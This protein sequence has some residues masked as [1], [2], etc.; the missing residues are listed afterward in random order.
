[1]AWMRWS[2]PLGSAILLVACGA[3][4]APRPTC[5]KTKAITDT[6]T[7]GQAA[8]EG[9]RYDPSAAILLFKASSSQMTIESRCN[10]RLVHKL[11]P[12]QRLASGS[13]APIAAPVV[14]TN[15]EF[16]L[17][18]NPDTMELQ[19]SAHCFFRV[20]DPRVPTQEESATRLDQNTKKA[21]SDPLNRYFLYKALLTNPQKLV[22]FD[23]AKNPVEFEYKLSS[24]DVYNI[25]FQKIEAHNS[26]SVRSIVGREFSKTSVILDELALDV[27]RAD[28]SILTQIDRTGTKTRSAVTDLVSLKDFAEKDITVL[29]FFRRRLVT[30]GR[31]KLCFSQTDFIVAPIQFTQTLEPAQ[32]THLNSIHNEQEKKVDELKQAIAN[33]DY[34]Q[35]FNVSSPPARMSLAA[36]SSC[37]W[38]PDYPGLS[39]THPFQEKLSTFMPSWQFDKSKFTHVPKMIKKVFPKFNAEQLAQPPFD[40]VALSFFNALLDQNSCAFRGF[41]YD[42]SSK[43]CLDGGAETQIRRD[44]SVGAC[45]SEGEANRSEAANIHMNVNASLRLAFVSPLLSLEK[46]REIH[47]ESLL[48]PIAQLRDITQGEILSSVSIADKG[49]IKK[50]KSSLD[51]MNAEHGRYTEGFDVL[52]VDNVNEELQ[53]NCSLKSSLSIAGAGNGANTQVEDVFSNLSEKGKDL[54]TAGL[55]RSHFNKYKNLAAR[56]LKTRCVNAGSQL[57]YSGLRQSPGLLQNVQW[58]EASFVTSDVVPSNG[59]LS[60]SNREMIET[61]RPVNLKFLELILG[62]QSVLNANGTAKFSQELNAQLLG[63]GHMQVGYCSA[64]GTGVRGVCDVELAHMDYLESSK[65]RNPADYS[66]G[67]RFAS[68]NPD[69]LLTEE[70][71]IRKKPSPMD[72]ANALPKLYAHLNFLTATPNWLPESEKTKYGSPTFPGEG[73]SQ[74]SARYFLSSGDS[75][76][77]ISLFGLFPIFMLSTVQDIPVS[78]GLAVIPS[79]GGQVV[80]PNKSATCR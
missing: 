18:N 64:Q 7:G 6:K 45:P 17:K 3:S 44:L 43:K 38:M 47:K 54:I 48:L 2:L 10:A 11:A 73:F 9:E 55:S 39:V 35:E 69:T 61:G 31:H 21:L 77:T 46:Y 58:A 26:D 5:S 67:G 79:T 15:L 22:V 8:L 50:I 63:T 16:D 60:L 65:R 37:G 62:R 19:T 66:P 74:D 4:R 1:M 25:F 40:Q 71:V 70:K 52:T 28:S 68:L 23:R 29:D 34:F 30:D 27:C 59:Q 76:T 32:I 57:L 75:G 80:Q 41:D 36:T 20:W 56:Y 24:Q 13:F 42:D 72:F 33:N 51:E 78:G 12:V 49:Q 53:L 14:F